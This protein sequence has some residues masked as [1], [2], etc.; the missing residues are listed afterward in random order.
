MIR[1]DRPLSLLE[2]NSIVKQ[3]ISLTLPDTFW[4]QAE[5]SDVHAASNGH[6]YLEFIQKDLRSNALVARARATIWRNVYTLLRPHFEQA[7]GHA[8]ASGIK[9]QVLVKVEYHELYGLTLTVYD[10][11]PTYTLGDL[12]QRRREILR[13]LE[14]E[15]VLTLN[16]ELEMPLLPQRIAV[17]SSATAA[18]YGDF[19][20]QLVRNA[21]GYRFCVELFPAVMQGDRTEESLLAALDAVMKREADAFDV[22]VIIRGGG[23]TSDLAAFDSY[24]LA[25][26]CAQFPLPIITGIG[27]ERDDTVLDL[28][29]HTRVK[30]PTAAAGFLI[31]RMDE[32]AQA[33]DSLADRLIA[34]VDARLQSEKYK[35]SSLTKRLPAV[36]ARRF[37][38]ARYTLRAAR[39]LM[40]TSVTNRFREERQRLTYLNERVKN[41][42]P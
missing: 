40:R 34:S 38:D 2:L 29:A 41:A 7:T 39:Q 27:H 1:V 42:S 19:C 37:G 24:M 28:V 17:I 4:I 20:D 14:E 32:A 6:C 26:A 30:T 36:L 15:G 13:K 18:G 12:A 21:Q 10:I 11:D 23:A 31:E 9:V 35:L 8:F 16:K 3:T 5:T 25:A 22:V 33:L